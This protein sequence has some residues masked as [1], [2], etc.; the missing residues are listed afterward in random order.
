VMRL[1]AVQARF[2]RRRLLHPHAAT[3]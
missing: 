3:V 1:K 2:K